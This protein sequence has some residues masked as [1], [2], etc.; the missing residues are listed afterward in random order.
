MAK[1]MQQE[2]ELKRAQMEMEE[3]KRAEDRLK[4]ELNCQEQD[5]FTLE[6]KYQSTEE[7]VQKMTT[8]LEKLW[9]RHKDA[10]QEIEELQKECQD[11]R[12]DMLETIRELTKEVK[13]VSLTIDRFIPQEMYQKIA[14]RAQW[15]S[16][17]DEW[18]IHK[19]HLAGNRR[20]MKRGKGMD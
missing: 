9:H 8:K 17:S 1:A 11:E 6:E 4:E 15:D 5:K 13:L 7:Q 12:E 16:S 20:N 3:K 18:I 14:D 10:Q 2:Q 19:V